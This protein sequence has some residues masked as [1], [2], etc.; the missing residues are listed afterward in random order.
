MSYSVL[1]QLNLF[2]RHTCNS[3]QLG[4][5]CDPNLLIKHDILFILI[6]VWLNLRTI[7]FVQFINDKSVRYFRVQDIKR[8]KFVTFKLLKT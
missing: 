5:Q 2:L 6:Y 1:K 3:R 8:T 7:N 4:F